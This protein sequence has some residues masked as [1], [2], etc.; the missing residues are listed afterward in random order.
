MFF[1]YNRKLQRGISYGGNFTTISKYRTRRKRTNGLLY[2]Q[3]CS[4]LYAQYFDH[5]LKTGEKEDISWKTNVCCSTNLL[6]DSYP[7]YFLHQ[8]I[9]FN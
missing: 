3:Y 5:F 1:C 6:G 4:Y 9:H 7:L 2:S 8:L